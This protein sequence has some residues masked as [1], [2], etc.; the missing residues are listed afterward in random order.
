M[1]IKVV[2]KTQKYC[3]D[4]YNYVSLYLIMCIKNNLLFF[5]QWK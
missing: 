2:I 1:N 3:I 4:K 5:Q